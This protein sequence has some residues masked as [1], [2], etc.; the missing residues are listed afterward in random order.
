MF[1]L[2][3]WVISKRGPIYPPMF[4]SLFLIISTVLD[5]VLLGTN[6]YLGT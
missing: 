6:I 4:N 5:S 1:V 3:S 2:I